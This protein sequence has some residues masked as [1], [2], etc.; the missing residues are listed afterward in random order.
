MISVAL[1][2]ADRYA[3]VSLLCIT[4]WLVGQALINIGVVVGVF[5]VMG[6][7]MPFVSAGRRG[8]LAHARPTSDQGRFVPRLTGGGA[9]GE[10][11]W[12]GHKA[13]PTGRNMSKSA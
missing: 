10:A 11:S 9:V 13:L 7:P 5:P 12:G 4:V 8:R 3:S 1:Q 2:T 6:V